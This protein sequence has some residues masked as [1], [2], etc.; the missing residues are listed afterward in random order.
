MVFFERRMRRYLFGCYISMHNGEVA[1][2][3][4]TLGRDR[5]KRRTGLRI[6]KTGKKSREPQCRAE[7]QYCAEGQRELRIVQRKMEFG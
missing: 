4:D 2:G 6:E 5:K 3:M 1:E 7:A